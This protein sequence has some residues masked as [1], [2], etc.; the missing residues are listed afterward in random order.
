MYL[1]RGVE[2]L[3]LPES[4]CVATIGNF[5]GVH[6]GHRAVIDSLA[7]QG[8]RLGLPVAVVLFEPQ[9]REFFAPE[10]APARLTRL[11]EK[12]VQLR[13]SPV[14]IVLLL[15]FDGRLAQTEPETFIQRIL[16]QGL[17]VKHLVVGD[18]FRFG[19]AR[20]GDFALLR[21]AGA[22]LGFQVEDTPS[23][24][25]AGERASSTLVREALA[26]GD[27]A[28]AERFLG[29]PYSMTGRVR[30]GA[31]LGRE[32][33]FPTANIVLEREK[34]PLQGVFAVTMTG[35]SA[36]P[37]AGVANLGSRPTVDGSR[38]MQLETHLFDFADDLYGRLVEVHFH[39]KLR[40]EQR[41]ES[42]AALREQIAKDADAARTYFTR[43]PLI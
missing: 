3:A 41:F 37:W 14:D 25:V 21:K 7:A 26:A 36:A 12:L 42:L 23:V 13:S 43:F 32:W 27:L 34:T 17:R 2:H 11:R 39:R 28:R 18:D 24:L 10:Q 38:R 31:K 9:A 20:A 1:A 16:V 4:G 35:F 15:R 33:G 22:S 6:L 40:D 29:R 8:G 19:Q 5:D 30:A